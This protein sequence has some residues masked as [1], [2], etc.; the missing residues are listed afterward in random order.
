ML[1][2]TMQSTQCEQTVVRALHSSLL[3]LPSALE[4]DD[5]GVYLCTCKYF[6]YCSDYLSAK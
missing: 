4:F 6:E 2:R 3:C 1:M 5:I